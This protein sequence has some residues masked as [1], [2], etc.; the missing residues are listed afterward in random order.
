MKTPALAEWLTSPVATG[1]AVALLLL[2]NSVISSYALGNFS[3]LG[4]DLPIHLIDICTGLVAALTLHLSGL[5]IRRKG[6]PRAWQTIGAWLAAAAM[7]S[8]VPNVWAWA[9]NKGTDI[10]ALLGPSITGTIQVI[11]LQL[12]FT[13]VVKSFSDNR[14]A[15]AYLE[16]RRQTLQLS[17][18][19]FVEQRSE[20]E[21]RMRVAVADK[22]Q[23]VLDALQKDLKNESRAEPAAL[24]KLILAGLNQGVRP[25]SWEIEAERTALPQLASPA[26]QRIS[27]RTHLTQAIR[28]PQAFNTF[29]FTLICVVFE[30]V[31]AFYVFGIDGALQILVTMTLNLVLLAT[32]RALAAQVQMP[33]WLAITFYSAFTFLTSLSFV[34]LRAVL[35]QTQDLD[36]ALAFSINIFE[37]AAVT[38]I[39][40]VVVQQRRQANQEAE[41]INKQ[42]E[43]AVARVRQVAWQARQ[44][45]ARLVHGPVQSKLLAAYLQLNNAKDLS[46]VNLNQITQDIAQA[47]EILGRQDEATALSVQQMTTWVTEGWGSEHSFDVVLDPNLL[48]PYVLDSSASAALYETLRESVNNAIKYGSAG[49][50]AITIQLTENNLIELTVVNPVGTSNQ[51]SGG[52]GTAVLDQVTYRHSLEIGPEVAV[53]KALIATAQAG[54][55]SLPM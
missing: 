32:L 24:A 52:Y 28:L 51:G 16:S 40:T 23:K 21:E 12:A 31:T 33:A 48:P 11:T 41:L 49:S 47:A 37:I 26:I 7:L 20:I 44:R 4:N 25:L 10:Q 38:S 9:L 14:S 1:R 3:L 50:Y 5:V 13:M 42:L 19:A 27:L 30:P 45:F 8:L 18:S 22:L 2:V 34:G 36:Y 15:A 35:G 17:Q 29:L 46:S 53:F 54:D 55:A 39:I 6:Q 43:V